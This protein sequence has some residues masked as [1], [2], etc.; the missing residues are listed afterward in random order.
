[1][2][3][4]AQISP[5]PQIGMPNMTMHHSQPLDRIIDGSCS[6]EFRAF[7]IKP[8]RNPRDLHLPFLSP[9]PLAPTALPLGVLYRAR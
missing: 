9:F 6:P 7:C 5:N 8:N 3:E 1:M 2:A 4:E